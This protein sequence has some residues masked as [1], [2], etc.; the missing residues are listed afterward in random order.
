MCCK[1]LNRLGHIC[2]RIFT[3]DNVVDNIHE[4]MGIATG[5]IIS[6]ITVIY[7]TNMK[8]AALTITDVIDKI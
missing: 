4:K 5:I 2:S 6:N 3:K 8:G 7:Q 1:S